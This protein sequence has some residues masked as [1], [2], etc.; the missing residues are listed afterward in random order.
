MNE[1]LRFVKSEADQECVHSYFDSVAPE[2]LKI[3]ERSDVSAVVH[4]QRQMTV[5]SLIDKLALPLDV[6]SLPGDLCGPRVQ[7]AVGVVDVGS[8]HGLQRAAD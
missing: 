6:Q 3:Y 7:A 5:L 1:P 4:Q 2:W 8:G